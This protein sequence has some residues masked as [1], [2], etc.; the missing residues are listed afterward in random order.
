MDDCTSNDDLVAA[1]S[2][3]IPEDDLGIEGYISEEFY[4]LD[5]VDC[6]FPQ[7]DDNIQYLHELDR[8]AIF[9]ATPENWSS[10]LISNVGEESIFVLDTAR[11]SA[12]KECKDELAHLQSRVPSLLNL[13]ATESVSL[14]HLVELAFGSNS[15][16]TTLFCQELSMSHE[17]FKRFFGTLCL[18]MS[19]KKETDS[20]INVW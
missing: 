8:E 14:S 20:S 6:P 11:S 7:V 9:N 1:S 5:I 3:F 2:L 15:S 10:C 12:W 4:G 19:Y 16:F 17:V 13:D 18:Q